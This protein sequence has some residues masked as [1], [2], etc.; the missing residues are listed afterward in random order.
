[1][2]YGVNDLLK[3]SREELDALFAQSPAGPIPN[4]D[5]KGTAILDP[6]SPN[7]G[8]L[9]EFAETL[10][11]GK[12]FDAQNGTLMNRVTVFGVK[13]IAAKVYEGDSLFD[14]KK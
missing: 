1:M 4:G 6:G 5:A 9:A 11:Q 14:K 8:Q 7:A 3:M 2:P 13:A 10:W 12:T